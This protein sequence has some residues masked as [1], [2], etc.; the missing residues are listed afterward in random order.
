MQLSL[1]SA[2]QM[3]HYHLYRVKHPAGNSKC[4][5]ESVSLSDVFKLVCNSLTV[6]SWKV[7]ATFRH[8]TVI[9]LMW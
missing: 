7:M 8:H 4:A 3:R 1:K 9:S 5:Q 2:L 6:F